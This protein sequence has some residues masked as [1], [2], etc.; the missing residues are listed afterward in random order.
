[1]ANR[2]DAIVAPDDESLWELFH[3]NSKFTRESNFPSNEAVLEAM[4]EMDPSLSVRAYREIALP[5]PLPLTMPLQQAIAAR[6]SGRRMTVATIPLA[7]LAT[8]LDAAYG[9]TRDNAGT[10]FPRPFRTIPSAGALYPLEIFFHA[11][12]V[13]DLAAGIYHYDPSRRTIELAAPP[14]DVTAALKTCLVQPEVV[15]EASVI[16]FVTALFE[17]AAF[18]YDDRGYRFVLLEAGHLAQNL[19]LAATACE[20]ASLCV[21]GYYDHDLDAVLGL[22]GVTH[23]TVYVIAVGAEGDA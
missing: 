14:G 7:E 16:I 21:G 22:N 17:R 23:S 18:K 3:E 8:F 6:V 1:M 11:S 2:W 10:E 5:P 19:L 20:R 12:R 9:I 4:R 15:D 13:S